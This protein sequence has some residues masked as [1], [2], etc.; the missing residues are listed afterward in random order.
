[1]TAN[2]DDLLERL[3]QR[4]LASANSAGW[5]YYAGKASRVEPTCWALLALASDG[6]HAHDEWLALA[7]RH[8][9]YL[10]GLQGKDGL[11]V[12]TE[13]A[14]ANLAAN[15]LAAIM[16]AHLSARASAAAPAS[17]T[18]A[19]FS[20]PALSTTLERLHAALVNLKGVRIEQIDPKQDSTLQGWPWVRDTFSWVEPT[21]WCLLA[22]KIAGQ[23]PRSTASSARQLEAERLLANRMC[24][25]GGWNFGNAA[26]LGQDLRAYVPTTAVALL[27]VQDK[28]AETYVAESFA[29]L[30]SHRIAEP[31]AMTL[32]L[33]SV[34]LRL[35][36]IATDDVDD[37]LA[38]AVAN[39]EDAGNV[40]AVAMT[41][42]ALSADQHQGDAFRVA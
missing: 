28:R 15:A 37:R 25:G 42:Y 18:V 1:M 22:L 27:S 36:G 2:R 19:A 33:V 5:G 38:Q 13:P 8:V 26:A 7:N 31:G 16:L 6:R 40:Q 41:M 4:L 34:C 20:T 24:T 29:M 32:A 17:T 23:Q 39:S 21:A 11:L 12:E 10:V 14:L 3:R 9:A 35:Y 30:Q